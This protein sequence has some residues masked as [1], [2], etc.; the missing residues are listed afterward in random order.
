MYG[1]L[2]TQYHPCNLYTYVQEVVLVEGPAP[3]SATAT[4]KATITVDGQPQEVT[5]APL[6]DAAAA[7]TAEK[8][9]VLVSAP[10]RVKQVNLHVH[11]LY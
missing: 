10:E 11:S 1:D 4:V 2:G 9:Y 3:S 8:E 7:A 6:E 5:L